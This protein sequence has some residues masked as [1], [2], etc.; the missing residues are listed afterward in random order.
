[1]SAKLEKEELH[2]IAGGWITERKHTPIPLFLKLAYVGFS[3]FGLYY[4]VAYWTGETTH[5][6][7]GALVTEMNR[8]LEAP[9]QWWHAVLLV[10]L[11]TFVAG[12]L[13]FALAGKDEE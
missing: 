5:P 8:V 2:E 11:G 13:W 1:M 9:A 3:L 10:I 7:R 4:L 6:T 12:L